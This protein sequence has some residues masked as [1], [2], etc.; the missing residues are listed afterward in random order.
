MTK[1]LLY[2]F[3]FLSVFYY[4]QQSVTQ[5]Y[6]DQR[7][8]EITKN[9]D[10]KNTG[11]LANKTYFDSKSINYNLG[12]I[13]SLI[14]LANFNYNLGK[15]EEVIKYASEA[16]NMAY[17]E[18]NIQYIAESLQQ[19]GQ[20]F[21]ELGFTEKANEVYIKAL[22]YARKIKNHNEK[23]FRLG[24]IS[25]ALA[26]NKEKIG[27]ANDSVLSYFNKS[28]IYYQK[29]SD[30]FKSKN[31]IMALSY[32]NIGLCYLKKNDYRLA[33]ENVKKAIA[34]NDTKGG[35]ELLKGYNFLALGDIYLKEKKLDSSMIYYKKGWAIGE[36]FK[37]P[38]LRKDI[39][40]GISTVFKD[41]GKKDSAQIFLQ[42]YV[43]VTDSLS[44]IEMKSVK[45]PLKQILKE[46]DNDF[47]QSKKNIYLLS[48]FIIALAVFFGFTGI[49]NS[50][51]DKKKYKQLIQKLKTGEELK[52]KNMLSQDSVEN[53]I[54]DETKN[55]NSVKISQKKES[56][57]LEKIKWFEQNHH[58]TDPNLN[59]SV[60]AGMLNTNP[61]Y[62]SE[63][64]KKEKGKNYNQYMNEIRINYIVNL[65]YKDEKFRSYKISYLATYCGFT[66]RNVF[67]SVFKKET[68]ISPSTFITELNK[69]HPE[70]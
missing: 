12:M 19:K 66:S 31:V 52:E 69:D 24:F 50:I 62:L 17:K 64:I 6:I 44:A 68:G 61:R 45:T 21:T 5:K 35:N 1:I 58:F 65:L 3:I 41:S 42:K 55:D 46:K 22:G 37:N 49:R 38:Y 25:S 67:A 2:L 30:D 23:N 57:I 16:E 27:V 29:L 34:L 59:M 14:I 28:L 48:F 43:T 18:D 20:G 33:V 60:L 53:A 4:G 8:T 51:R 54:L 36:K 13:K 47:N 10:S 9:A 40:K 70:L 7:I 56:E 26:Y 15:Y 63:I 11:T 39:Y 32:N